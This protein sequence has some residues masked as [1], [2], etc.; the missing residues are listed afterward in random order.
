MLLHAEKTSHAKAGLLKA[1]E[2][3][4]FYSVHAPLWKL[5]L[6]QHGPNRVVHV[7]ISSTAEQLPK[8]ALSQARRVLFSSTPETAKG[9]M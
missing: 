5:Y 2:Q 1:A 9:N 7:S 6:H 3:C 4:C 8:T